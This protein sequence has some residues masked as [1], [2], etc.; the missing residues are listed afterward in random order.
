MDRSS[1]AHAS[2][3]GGRIA[4]I[5]PDEIQ[6]DGSR[7]IPRTIHQDPR[8]FLVETLRG[9]DETARRAPFAMSYTSVTVPGEF[10]DIDRWHLH[11][12]QSDRFVVALGEMILALYDARPASRTQGRLEVIRMVGAPIDAPGHPSKRDL[13]TH[14]VPIPPGVLH[15]IGNISSAP[16]VLQNYPTHLYSAADEGRVPFV[17]QT[18]AALRGPFSW[19]LVP[20]A[21]RR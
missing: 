6:I 12:I 5:A 16:F 21:P 11:T 9:D 10:R 13:T 14:L 2:H 17:E 15:V 18:V 3:E 19:D 8:G 20:R 4:L 7:P 1:A